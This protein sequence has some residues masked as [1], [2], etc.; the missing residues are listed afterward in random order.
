LAANSVLAIEQV[1]AD[2]QH[3]RV[4]DEHDADLFWALRGGGGS[5]G[6]VTAIEFRLYPIVQVHAG[7]LFWPI[8]SAPEVLHAYRDWV[9]TVPSSVTSVGR[10]LRFPPLPELPDHLRGR[11]FVVIEAACQLA[12]AEA[13]RLLAAL[14]RLGPQLDTFAPTPVAELGLLHMDPDG[15]VPAFGDGMLLADLHE[16][17]VEA[18]LHAAG[19]ASGS[20]LLSVELRHL[21]G[22]LS[23]G[24]CS[25]GAVSGID[26]E[27]AVFGVGITPDAEADRAV[28][29]SV[30]LLHRALAPWSA[31]G[32]YLNFAERPK[33][34][35]ALFGEAVYRRLQAV[36]ANHD[37]ADVIRANHPVTPAKRG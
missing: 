32:S 2:G 16:D 22:S 14:R 18:L 8:D 20:P 7:A 13:D 29:A 31:G 25:G 15:P 27:F 35:A 17:A 21:G 11:S 1:T 3:R 34:G 19:P 23:P 36:K 33:A 5:F 12:A 4:D 10:M 24:R 9:T 28:R 37:P 6:V 30:D 26:A